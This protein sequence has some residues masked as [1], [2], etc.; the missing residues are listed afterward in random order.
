VTGS[1]E[2]GNEHSGFIKDGELVI[3]VRCCKTN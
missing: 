1:C 3:L 2:R